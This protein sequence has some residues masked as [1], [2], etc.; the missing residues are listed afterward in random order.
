MQVVRSDILGTLS[1]GRADGGGDLFIK[2]LDLSCTLI[3]RY[4]GL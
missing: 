2:L 3:D 4:L 1:A